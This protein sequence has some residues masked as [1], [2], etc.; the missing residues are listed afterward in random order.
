MTDWGR[1][2]GLYDRQLW[3]ERA[4]LDAAIDLAEIEADG[5]VLDLGTGTAALLRRLGRRRV[6]FAQAIGVDSSPQML[7][8]ASALPSG[9]ELREADATDLPF[10]SDSFDV[11]FASYLLHLLEKEERAAVLVEARRV[12]RPEGRV[13]VVTVAEPRS[14]LVRLVLSPAVS[15][16]WRRSSTLLGL[17]PLDPRPD[18]EASGFAVRRTRR[19]LWG[20]PSTVVMAELAGADAPVG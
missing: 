8:R 17:R 6:A 7:A 12:M 1:I 3:L 14:R 18:L 20:Y 15:L 2:A 10:P 16:A 13:V 19:V 4:A 5:R 9:C 11:V